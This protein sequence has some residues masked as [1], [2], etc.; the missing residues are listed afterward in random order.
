MLHLQLTKKELT[1]EK[2]WEIRHFGTQSISIDGIIDATHSQ[3]CLWCSVSPSLYNLVMLA[4]Q[5]THKV[6]RPFLC[7]ILKFKTDIFN[8]QRA[9]LINYITYIICF[10]KHL[11]LAYSFTL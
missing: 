10:L 3:Y 8:E 7:I 2:R 6:L 1:L 5:K 11:Y 9:I 4:L